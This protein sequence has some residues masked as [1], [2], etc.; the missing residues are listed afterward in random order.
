MEKSGSN[1]KIHTQKKHFMWN[2][3]YYLYVLKQ[4]DPT[5]YTGL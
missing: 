3:M 5:D 2:Y 4:K 1:F